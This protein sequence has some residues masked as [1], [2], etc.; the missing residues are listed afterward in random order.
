MR[1]DFRPYVSLSSS[2]SSAGVE[3]SDSEKVTWTD[4]RDTARFLSFYVILTR[5]TPRLQRGIWFAS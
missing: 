3:T 2:A 4:L 5:K 1:Q